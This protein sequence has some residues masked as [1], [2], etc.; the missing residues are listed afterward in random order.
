[1]ILYLQ[2]IDTPEDRSKFER[3]YYEYR[4]LMFCIAN[5]ILKNKQDAEDMVHAAFVSIAENMDKIDAP[6]CPKTKAY[7]ATIVTHK[8]LDLRRRKERH[9]TVPLDSGIARTALRL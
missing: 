3:L 8:A 1:M 2:I 6:I 9:P 4:G 7:A 5:E